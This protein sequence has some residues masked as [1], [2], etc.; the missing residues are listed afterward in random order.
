VLASLQGVNVCWPACMS[1]I[2]AGKPAGSQH[3]LGSLQEVNMCWPACR[4]SICA[5]QPAGRAAHLTE[6]L[7]AAQHGV[8]GSTGSTPA[9]EELI[10]HATAAGNVLLQDTIDSGRKKT[11]GEW[12]GAVP[13]KDTDEPINHSSGHS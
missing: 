3:V 2:S 1:I 13:L 7:S 4:K 5:G 12:R 6:V 10:N 11:M 9:L 8:L